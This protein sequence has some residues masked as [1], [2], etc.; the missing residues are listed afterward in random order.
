[1]LR[2]RRGTA[3]S[4]PAAALDHEIVTALYVDEAGLLWLGTQGHG[5]QLLDGEQVRGFTSKDG[6]Y[7]DDIFGLVLDHEQRYGWPAAKAC[8]SSPGASC[9]TLPPGGSLA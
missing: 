2:A 7:D 1:M 8:S 9:G 3:V 5:L 4:F 6:L